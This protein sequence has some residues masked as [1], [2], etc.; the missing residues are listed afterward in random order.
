MYSYRK[1]TIKY[2]PFPAL[3][4]MLVL[5]Q[6]PITSTIIDDLFII[7][8]YL[9][10]QDVEVTKSIGVKSGQILFRLHR[11]DPLSSGSYACE[12]QTKDPA[13]R[14]TSVK[15][16]I[17]PDP[18]VQKDKILTHLPLE[19]ENIIVEPPLQKH[20]ETANPNASHQGSETS[21]VAIAT[22]AFLALSINYV[23]RVVSFLK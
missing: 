14:Y 2:S 12:V 5:P 9:L 11:I 13:L 15:E 19:K 7:N 6:I 4:P 16:M 1:E 10:F 20:N 22:C 21:A 18:A 23:A 17:V 8:T 3:M